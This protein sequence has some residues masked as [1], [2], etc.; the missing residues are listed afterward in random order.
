LRTRKYITDVRLRTSG[1]VVEKKLD[2]GRTSVLSYNSLG[3][4]L[5]SCLRSS[6]LLNQERVVGSEVVVV[7]VNSP[8]SDELNL[9]FARRGNLHAPILEGKRRGLDKSCLRTVSSR[10]DRHLFDAATHGGTGNIPD[11]AACVQVVE[12]RNMKQNVALENRARI[13]LVRGPSK[14]MAVRGTFRP[15]REQRNS[16]LDA[17]GLGRAAHGRGAYISVISGVSIDAVLVV[18][19]GA[20]SASVVSLAILDPAAH[21]SANLAFFEVDKLLRQ[22]NKARN[23]VGIHSDD[24]FTRIHRKDIDDVAIGVGGFAGFVPVCST[25]EKIGEWTAS[26]VRACK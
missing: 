15:A 16:I 13:E 4:D 20:V 24:L 22:I 1:H 3:E 21:G 14:S 23:S 9:P 17:I 6:F 7:S 2:D 25:C 18:R 8:T 26:D 5:K 10:D 12:K 11:V 19:R